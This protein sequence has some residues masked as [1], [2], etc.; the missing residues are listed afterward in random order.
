MALNVIYNLWVMIFILLLLSYE[1][2]RLRLQRRAH[3]ATV[4]AFIQMWM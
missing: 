1:R 3:S 4:I 2:K